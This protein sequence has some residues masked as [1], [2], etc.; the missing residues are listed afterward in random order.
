MGATVKP[1]HLYMVTEFCE[2]GNMQSII[3]DK[4]VKLSARRT[5]R[6]ALDA[7]R[8]M[9]YLHRSTPPILHRDYKSANCMFFEHLL[10]I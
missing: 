6:L 1:P 8:G 9:L 3:R 5:C 2:R 4:R 7:A 10:T